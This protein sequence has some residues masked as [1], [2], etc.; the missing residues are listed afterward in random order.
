[1]SSLRGA[2]TAAY[3]PAE[4]GENVD[5]FVSTMLTMRNMQI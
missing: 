4:C 5:G 3:C 1:M 2:P